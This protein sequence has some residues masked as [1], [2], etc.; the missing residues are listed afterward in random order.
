MMSE[1]KS[2][3]TSYTEADN[4]RIV[5]TDTQKN[6]LFAMAKKYPVSPQERWSVCQFLPSVSSYTQ[7]LIG[8]DY[9]ARHQHL[10][11]LTVRVERQ[12]WTRLVV[13]GQGHRHAFQRGTGTRFS[14]MRMQRDAVQLSAGFY[15][16]EVLVDCSLL[17]PSHY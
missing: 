3:T 7:I 2:L 5:P 14:Q 8:R 6:T 11:A 12:P 9:L 4:S 10:D 15:D 13:Q 16:L 17:T 1:G